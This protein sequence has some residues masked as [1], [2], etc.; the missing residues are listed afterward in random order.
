MR[1]LVKRE[2]GCTESVAFKGSDVAWK[3]RE[4]MLKKLPCNKCHLKRMRERVSTGVPTLTEMCFGPGGGVMALGFVNV[5]CKCGHVADLDEFC[6]TPV[7]GELPKGEYQCPACGYA[8]KRVFSE[9]KT[10]KAGG[11]WHAIPGKCELV[12]VAGRL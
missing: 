12:Q 3:E 1:Y 10:F 7:F 6:R 5:T 11:E 4:R 8:F 2:C 9:V